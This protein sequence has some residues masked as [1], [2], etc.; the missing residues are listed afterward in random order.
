MEMRSGNIS[1]TLAW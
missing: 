1:F